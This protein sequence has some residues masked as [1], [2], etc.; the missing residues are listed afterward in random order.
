MRRIVLLLAAASLLAACTGSSDKPDKPKNNGLPDGITTQPV[1]SVKDGELT[2]SRY[3][4]LGTLPARIDGKEVQYHGLTDDGLAYGA[5][6]TGHAPTG[7]VLT[8]LSTGKVTYLAA[9]A[10]GPGHEV[11]GMATAPGWVVWLDQYPADAY[12]SPH[13]RLYSYE[14]A[15]HRVRML[16]ASTVDQTGATYFQLQP[17]IEKGNVYLSAVKAKAGTPKTNDDAYV[18]PLDGSAPIKALGWGSYFV[19]A[20]D[21]V[22]ISTRGSK[23]EW[24]NVATG[25]IAI[26]AHCDTSGED[27]IWAAGDGVLAYEPRSGDEVYDTPITVIDA[28][29]RE[30]TIDTPRSPMDVDAASSRWVTFESDTDEYVYD[31][32]TDEALRMPSGRRAV[33][34]TGGGDVMVWVYGNGE[35]ERYE[36]VRLK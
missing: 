15:T 2:P 7:A 9:E 4:L 19:Q 6:V 20:G 25:K 23:L 3:S 1:P 31:L 36:F 18:V 27:C 29:G 21:G 33:S 28:S 11:G 16:A 32:R 24:R 12:G 5:V 17:S 14:R 22:I 13:W 35:R 26:A 30:R 10:D 8:N 34:N